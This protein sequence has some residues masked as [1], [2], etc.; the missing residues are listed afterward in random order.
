[1]FFFI[2]VS[3]LVEVEYL[4]YQCGCIA[5]SRELGYAVQYNIH[6][7]LR[8]PCA[9]PLRKAPLC[10]NP[11]VT[12][13]NFSSGE[14]VCGQLAPTIWSLCTSLPLLLSEHTKPLPP[15]FSSVSSPCIP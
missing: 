3:P 15:F 1:M 10:K 13:S 6:Y 9:S 8:H 4:S 5:Q 7:L 11:P 14:C 2:S 12:G